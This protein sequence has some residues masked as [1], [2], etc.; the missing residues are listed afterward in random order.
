MSWRAS[1]PAWKAMAISS[2][3]VRRARLLI[4]ATRLRRAG[5]EPAPDGWR[6][7]LRTL[8]PAS[9]SGTFA[10]HHAEYWE[11]VWSIRLGIGAPPFVAIWS[12]GHGKSTGAEAGTLA[13]GLRGQ[14]KYALYVGATQDAAN[15]R[16]SDIAAL[17]EKSVTTRYYPAHAERRVGKYGNSKGWRRDRLATAGGFVVDAAGL[18]SAIRGLKFGEQRPDLI[19]LD[20][21]DAKHD[22]PAVTR[23][24]MEIITHSILPATSPGAAVLFVQNLIIP[25]GVVSRLADGRAEFL[26]DRI[27]SGPH[28]AIRGLK[29]EIRT[30]EGGR[31]RVVIT[32]GTPTWE[33]R[34]IAWA[35]AEISKSS[36]LSFLEECQH[37]VKERV[38][39]LWTKLMIAECRVTEAPKLVRIVVAMDPS[40]TKTGDEHGIIVAGVSAAGHMYVLEDLSGHYAPNEWAVVAVQAYHRWKAD[41]IVAEANNGGDMIEALIRNVDPSVAYKKVH[42]TRDKQ[43]R[44][45]PIAA[46]Y[47]PDQQRVHHVGVLPELESE[48][49]TWVPGESSPNRLDALVWAG[50]DLLLAA[51]KKWEMLVA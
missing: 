51:P 13:L 46:F 9:F 10:P 7:W 43:T 30:D 37:E 5:G 35:E 36:L 49:T 32:A 14:R 1:S 40:A 50:T 23:K 47:E 38:G 24:K 29:T 19:I 41:T 17:L 42:A 26:M 28:P 11:W 31:K 2:E 3:D 21:I 15:K 8:F 4:R 20:D 45:M 6:E 25:D 44:A 16:V 48:M 34:D 33:S 39:A 27:V 22:S 12:R 18:D